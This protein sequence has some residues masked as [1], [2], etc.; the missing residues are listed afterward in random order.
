MIVSGDTP[1]G[2]RLTESPKEG[3]TGISLVFVL[4]FSAETFLARRRAASVVSGKRVCAS[5]GWSGSPGATRVPRGTPQLDSTFSLM[6]EVNR[7]H[8]S[9]DSVGYGPV[10]E[11]KSC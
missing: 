7:V 1:R 2:A 4:E 3:A 6:C 8:I 11:S 9:S 10:D 5:K